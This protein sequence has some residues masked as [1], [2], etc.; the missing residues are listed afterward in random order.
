MQSNYH[1]PLLPRIEKNR[2]KKVAK[3]TLNYLIVIFIEGLPAEI[4]TIQK[5]K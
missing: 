4:K 1:L 5:S 2:Q 3:I